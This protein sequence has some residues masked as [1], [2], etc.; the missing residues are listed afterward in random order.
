[1]IA[2]AFPR[3]LLLLV[4]GTAIAGGAALIVHGLMQL[5]PA[6]GWTPGGAARVAAWTGLMVLVLYVL[7][8][9]ARGRAVPFALAYLGVVAVGT[10]AIA[11]LL[12]VV[13]MA[14]AFTLVGQR[15]RTLWGDRPASLDDAI[16]S[17]LVGAGAYG[18]LTSVLAHW[19]INMAGL[20]LVLVAAPIAIDHRAARALLSDLSGRVKAPPAPRTLVPAIT[21][22]V[23]MLV[24]VTVAPLPQLG[25]DGLALHLLVPTET[26]GR[27]EW[28]YDVTRHVYAVIPMLGDWLMTV[29]L[30]FGGE[31]GARLLVAAFV[32]TL[33]FLAASIVR[34][35]GGR[36]TWAWFAG[37]L[38]LSTPIFFAIGSSL[39]IDAIWAAFVVGGLAL[40]FAHR[41]DTRTPR[42]VVTAAVLLGFSAA[43]KAVTLPLLPVFA[44]LALVSIG[45]LRQPARRNAVLLAFGAATLAAVKPYATAW[46]LTG[47]PVF[48]FYNEIFASPLFPTEG[49]TFGAPFRHGVRWDDLYSITLR[50]ERH[51][52]GGAGA[53]GFQWLLLL[54]ASVLLLTPR[55]HRRALWLP[56]SAIAMLVIT[57]HFQSYLR[58]VVPAFVILAA[59][60]ALAASRAADASPAIGKV[61]AWVGAIC[62]AFNAVFLNAAA[63]YR[64]FPLA[65]AF[66]DP[67][68]RRALVMEKAPHRLAARVAAELSQRT[69]RI[70]FLSAPA[71]ADAG[72]DAVHASWYSPAFFMAVRAADSA[73]ALAN[74]L[75]RWDIRHLV[76]HTGSA[77][78]PRRDHL[79]RVTLRVGSFGDLEI[80]KP[81]SGLVLTRELLRNSD[82]ASAE[83]WTLVGGARHDAAEKVI[84]VSSASPAYQSVGVVGNA[85]YLL[86]VDARCDRQETEGRL[87][88]IWH[89]ADRTVIRTEAETFP[90]TRDT[91]AHVRETI[92]PHDARAAV[93]Y[94]TGHAP[95]TIVVRGVSFKTN[96][97]GT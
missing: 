35:C 12:G 30:A 13:S 19:P 36:P 91:R 70:G 9:R 6:I 7:A 57:F 51:T 95:E 71:F 87:Q 84:V 38:V 47:N 39:L 62:V 44:V 82:F 23:L 59:T 1:M 86:T 58:Y 78:P 43:T 45:D 50:S 53:A 49:V 14:L 66:G 3:K 34:E 31:T 41:S 24:Y 4:A 83:G 81:R 48:P 80:R 96:R 92:A 67:A 52:E 61:A 60:I 65:A 5:R 54:P 94:A 73:E 15:L 55:E 88:I 69:G 93:V 89:A 28:H 32:G 10:G 25:W 76:V 17:M 68:A 90:C 64:D 40:L 22:S 20:Y 63:A 29:A 72:M 18:T 74:V 16:F 21:A 37:V 77:A 46:V 8:R 85:P 27:H 2:L 75:S 79:E 42:R 33:A 11:P 26:L 56:A 97:A